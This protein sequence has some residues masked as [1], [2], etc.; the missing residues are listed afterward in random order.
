MGPSS[1]ATR[2]L[3]AESVNPQWVRLLELLNMNV[4]YQRCQGVELFA[5]DG[6]RY[7]DFL[8]GYCVHNTGH[9]HPHIIE[10]LKQ[11]LE[12]S[13]PAMLQSHVP[14]LAG[15]LAQ[16]LCALSGGGL[17]KAFFCS[18]R[19]DALRRELHN[20]RPCEHSGLGA[21]NGAVAIIHRCRCR[22][23]SASQTGLQPVMQEV[24]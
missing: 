20:C 14:E 15:E 3:Y 9:N 24:A 2:G 6:R 7:L 8:S 19:D 21:T 12:R 1:I 17:T 4:R 11:E 23:G 13:G 10:A 22:V 5:E 16:R 18:S